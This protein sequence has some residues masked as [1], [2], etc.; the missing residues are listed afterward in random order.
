V[1]CSHIFLWS[2]RST[3]KRYLRDTREQCDTESSSHLPPAVT[4]FSTVSGYG[5]DGRANGFRCPA[6]GK[7]FSSNLCVQTGSKAH[8]ASCTMGTG[9][10]FPRA[11]R[12]QGVTLPTQCRDQEWVGAIP[13]FPQAPPGRVA[14]LLWSDIYGMFPRIMQGML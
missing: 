13:P 14:V 3:V 4:S 2:A 9:G 6:G 1:P 5:L 8:P 11:K 12:G 10:P 7:D